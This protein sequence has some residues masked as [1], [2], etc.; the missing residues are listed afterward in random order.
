[1]F[2]QQCSSPVQ[3]QDGIPWVGAV[4]AEGTFA[5]T[6]QASRSWLDLWLTGYLGFHFPQK[7]PPENKV[8]ELENHRM[9][10]VQNYL[11]GHQI[12]SFLPWASKS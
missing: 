8:T 12:L 10:W 9:V 5:G 1:M 11:K 6:L 7:T 4:A 3:S 2:E